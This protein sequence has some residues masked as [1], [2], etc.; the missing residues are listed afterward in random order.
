MFNSF[1][2]VTLLRYIISPCLGRDWN[3]S[4]KSPGDMLSGG[5]AKTLATG[6]TALPSRGGDEQALIFNHFYFVFPLASTIKRWMYLNIFMLILNF[7]Y[8]FSGKEI[9]A[10][11][12]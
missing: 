11:Q 8:S 7:L 6:G 4:E 10:M 12:K 3:V 1:I 5:P 9:S 2:L